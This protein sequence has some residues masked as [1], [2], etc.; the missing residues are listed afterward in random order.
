MS[1]QQTLSEIKNISKYQFTF[2]EKTLNQKRELKL[3]NFLI[4]LLN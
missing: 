2:D 3:N 1:F 4:K